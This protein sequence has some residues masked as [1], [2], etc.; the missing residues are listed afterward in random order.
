MARALVYCK[1]C[2]CVVAEFDQR[3]IPEVL[4]CPFCGVEGSF[5]WQKNWDGQRKTAKFH[6]IVFSKKGKA[7]DFLRLLPEKKAPTMLR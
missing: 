7:A 1:E 6:I 2:D 4:K 5:H 3:S